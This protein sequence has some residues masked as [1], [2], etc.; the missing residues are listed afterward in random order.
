MHLILSSESAVRTTTSRSALVWA[1][2]ASTRTASTASGNVRA[3]GG[4]RDGHDPLLAATVGP[5]PTSATPVGARSGEGPQFAVGRGRVRDRRGA[6]R[7]QPGGSP[8]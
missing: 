8:A 5:V 1:I 2:S 3:E 7:R 4:P 6:V